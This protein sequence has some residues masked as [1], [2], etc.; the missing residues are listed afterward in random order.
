MRQTS[1]TI[2][3][4]KNKD[5]HKKLFNAIHIKRHLQSL[6]MF[7]IYAC[8]CKPSKNEVV[9]TKKLI[10]KDLLTIYR[11]REIINPSDG[12]VN[13]RINDRSKTTSI[14]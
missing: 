11:D 12:I 2:L 6:F 9:E 14:A 1:D 5:E 13:E 3:Q 4:D 10:T 8:V 7:L